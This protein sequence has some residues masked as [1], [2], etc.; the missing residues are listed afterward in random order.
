MKKRNKLKG[1][2][3][4][5]CFNSCASQCRNGSGCASFTQEQKYTW[6]RHLRTQQLF[7][8]TM[9]QLVVALY[10][11]F[12]SFFILFIGLLAIV[13]NC[14][15]LRYRTCKI[16]HPCRIV[17]HVRYKPYKLKNIPRTPLFTVQFFCSVWLTIVLH[18]LFVTV[19]GVTAFVGHVGFVT[20]INW[21]YWCGIG[22]VVAEIYRTDKFIAVLL[23]LFTFLPQG[24]G[25]ESAE[26]AAHSAHTMGASFLGAVGVGAAVGLSKPSSSGKRKRHKPFSQTQDSN[27]SSSSHTIEHHLIGNL[28]HNMHLHGGDGSYEHKHFVR[29]VLDYCLLGPYSFESYSNTSVGRVLGVG[30]GTVRA[31]FRTCDSLSVDVSPFKLKKAPRNDAFPVQHA[32]EVLQ[33]VSLCTGCQLHL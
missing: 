9:Y 1:T 22:I 17:G 6:Q 30:E 15:S 7:T 8:I 26:H 25:M 11:S 18:L 27:Y 20:L 5:K 13:V 28:V 33:F 4:C 10:G 3:A 32:A 21:L 19:A 24:Y 23:L 16:I 12:M 14:F 2:S 29:K 31:R